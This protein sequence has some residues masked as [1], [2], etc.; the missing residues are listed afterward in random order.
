M[1]FTNE[2]SDTSRQGPNNTA[3]HSGDKIQVETTNNYNPFSFICMKCVN[4]DCTLSL[5][6]FQKDIRIIS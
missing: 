5:K 4:I 6:T 3:T 2:I 1:E